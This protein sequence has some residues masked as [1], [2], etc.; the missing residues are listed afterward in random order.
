MISSPIVATNIRP[1][2]MRAATIGGVKVATMR[3]M[4]SGA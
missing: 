2:A 4:I 1:S 3:S